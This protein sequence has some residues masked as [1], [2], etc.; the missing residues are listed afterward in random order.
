MNG[1]KYKEMYLRLFN[2]VTDALELLDRGEADRA[3]ELLISAQREAEE[4]FIAQPG[5]ESEA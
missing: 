2:R 1:Y 4:M 3:R 5:A